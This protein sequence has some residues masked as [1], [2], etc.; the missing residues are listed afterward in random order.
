MPTTLDPDA[1]AYIDAVVAVGATVSGAQKKAISEFY[2]TGKDEGWYANIKRLYLP[3]WAIA[4]P[5]AIDLIT[6]NSGTFAGTVTHSAGYITG[7]GSN[8]RMA[9]D[10]SPDALSIVDGDASISCLIYAAGAGSSFRAVIGVTQTAKKSFRIS[11][12]TIAGATTSAGSL[13]VDMNATDTT[14][15]GIY[16]AGETTTTN[17]FF[18]V[19]KTAGVTSLATNTSSSTGGYPTINAQIMAANN[20]S[21]FANFS[22]DSIGAAHIGLEFTTTQADQYSAALKTMWETC[23]GLTLP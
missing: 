11:R 16:V 22:N 18:R 21:S 2:A 19:R 12:N 13:G 9:M 15:G 20:N 5:N 14:F 4:S 10:T 6:T 3:I 17:R 8:A 23:T 7:N 1:Q